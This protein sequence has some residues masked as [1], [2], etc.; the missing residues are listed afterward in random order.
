MTMRFNND[1]RIR[2][3][4]ATEILLRE[5]QFLRGHLQR[6]EE[7]LR[8]ANTHL[9]V[10]RVWRDE[11]EEERAHLNL[12]RMPSPEEERSTRGT[13]KKRMSGSLEEMVAKV[14]DGRKKRR[15][16]SAF[17]HEFTEGN[18][19][20]F[21]VKIGGVRPKSLFGESVEKGS[22]QSNEVK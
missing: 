17:H 12:G 5:N 19:V 11:E 10:N 22:S 1:P 4:P 13:S 18:R 3:G 15:V 14:M 8:Q 7:E 9:D 21:M 6:V 20:P 2:Q 16:G